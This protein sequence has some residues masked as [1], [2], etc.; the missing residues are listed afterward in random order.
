MRDMRRHQLRNLLLGLI[1]LTCLGFTGLVAYSLIAE[2]E[3]LE[4]MRGRIPACK[5]VEEDAADMEA[6]FQ[7][8]VGTGVPA[9]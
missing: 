5:T 4:E 2:P 3:L 6:Y 9:G 8:L 1:S 7:K